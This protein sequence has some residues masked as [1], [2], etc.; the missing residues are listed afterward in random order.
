MRFAYRRTPCKST[1]MK[2]SLACLFSVSFC[3]LAVSCAPSTPE[4]RIAEKPLAFEKLSR[5]HKELVRRG[6]IGKGMDMSAVALAWGNPS[7]R[8]EGFS[9]KGR[10]ER[11]EYIG[12]QPVMMNTF[13]D[14]YRYDRIHPHRYAR[15]GGY[16]G[17]EI[18]YV[19]Y[20][21]STVWFVGGKVT[22]WERL[23]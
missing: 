13:Y 20:R 6:E 21:K 4:A 8:M 5:E 19:P 17:T 16:Y 11:W 15:A 1:G 18:V 23:K 9:G 22:E 12:S 7:S 3:L 14:S 2:Q 10:T